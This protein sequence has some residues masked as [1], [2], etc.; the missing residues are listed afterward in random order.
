MLELCCDKLFFL[1][2]MLPYSAQL[3][4]SHVGIGMHSTSWHGEFHLRETF[5]KNGFSALVTL[6]AITE[7][8]FSLHKWPL[9]NDL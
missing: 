8:H 3:Y 5:H 6:P 4:I 1:Q 7:T 9:C 2:L